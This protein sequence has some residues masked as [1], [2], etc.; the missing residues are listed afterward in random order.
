MLGNLSGYS[1][2]KSWKTVLQNLGAITYLFS[3]SFCLL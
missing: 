1:M 3:A 2:A